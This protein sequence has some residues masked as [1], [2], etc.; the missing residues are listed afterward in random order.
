MADLPPVTAEFIGMSRATAPSSEVRN[1]LSSV[2]AGGTEYA[3]TVANAIAFASQKF[4]NV[5]G[6]LP[7]AFTEMTG[8][9]PALAAMNANRG[10]NVPSQPVG[11]GQGSNDIAMG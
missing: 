4:N 8:S 5:I 3:N 1:T 10:A 11:T 7:A 9:M 2:E 6:D